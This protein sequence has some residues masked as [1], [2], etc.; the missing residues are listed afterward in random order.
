MKE[1]VKLGHNIFLIGNPK[2]QLTSIGVKLIP[3]NTNN[4]WV[5]QIPDSIDLFHLFYTPSFKIPV[6]FLVT[7]EGNG[8]P[9]TRVA[10]ATRVRP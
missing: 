7:I 2:S 5:E 6:P 1:L 4:H 3:Q 10:P 8:Q 9:L